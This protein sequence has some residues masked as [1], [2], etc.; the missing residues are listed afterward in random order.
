MNFSDLY[1][2]KCAIVKIL[3]PTDSDLEGKIQMT[4]FN[5]NEGKYIRFNAAK[6][7]IN[8]GDDNRI[9]ICGLIRK[10]LRFEHESMAKTLF[11]IEAELLAYKNGEI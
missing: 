6:I 10:P 2:I 1:D 11:T 4:V 3:F 9:I 5:S 8:I 7:S